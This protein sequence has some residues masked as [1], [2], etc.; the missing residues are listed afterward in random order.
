MEMQPMEMQP[1]EM[2]ARIQAGL[3]P[4]GVPSGY[5]PAQG[6]AAVAARG[7]RG[8]A[9]AAATRDRVESF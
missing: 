4:S 9:P 8:M 6:G 2:Q 3:D 5:P 1:M 7:A